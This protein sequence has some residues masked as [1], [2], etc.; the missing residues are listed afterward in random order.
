MYV[1]IVSDEGN[2]LQCVERNLLPQTKLFQQSL[3]QWFYGKQ[4]SQAFVLLYTYVFEG[5]LCI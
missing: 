2:P 1:L 3:L 5:I 4:Q